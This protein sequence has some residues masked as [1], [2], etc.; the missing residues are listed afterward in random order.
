MIKVDED[1]AKL[2]LMELAESFGADEKEVLDLLPVAMDGRLFLRADKAVYTLGK[3]IKMLAGDDLTEIVLREPQASDYV[4]YSKGMSVTVS[5]DGATEVD[6]IMMT[7]R[8]MR[9]VAT[10]AE[11]P[12]GI[13]D[14]LSVR[15][16]RTLGE[17]CEALGFFE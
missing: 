12:V 10:L 9:A 5:R 11:Q 8:T 13:V 17:V 16:V 15:D 14:K 6:A 4:S 2:A 1:S 7:R 3:S